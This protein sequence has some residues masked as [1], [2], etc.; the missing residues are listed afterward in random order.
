MFLVP[1][2]AGPAALMAPP[3]TKTLRVP[4]ES[5]VPTIPIGAKV[6]VNLDV[7]DHAKPK[8]GDIVILHP[9]EAA[10]V[11]DFGH[12]CGDAQRRPR[13][14]CAVAQPGKAS[15]RFIKRVVGL[16]GDRLSLRRGRLTRNGKRVVEPFIDACDKP[17]D[18]HCDFTRTMTV[19]AGQYF[20]LGDNRVP[21]TTA[22]TGARCLGRPCCG[23]WIA[24]RRSRRS[25]ADG[26]ARAAGRP[27]RRR[28][29]RRPARR[30]RAWRV[31]RRRG[32]A[33]GPS[34]G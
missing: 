8:F 9:P 7:Y 5:M 3:H 1:I 26:G 31:P 33:A 12:E 28:R 27:G 2:I 15:E 6:L 24:A 32:T 19:P 20:M 10:I 22:A 34:R 30:A 29:C 13:Q 11:G 4:S 16:P 23:V 25:A 18:D 17:G 14:M 21:R